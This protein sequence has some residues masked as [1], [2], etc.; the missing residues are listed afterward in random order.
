[1]VF[2]H[3]AWRGPEGVAAWAA[4]HT[5]VCGCACVKVD[6][7]VVDETVLR[8]PTSAEVTG[9]L[10]NTFRKNHDCTNKTPHTWIRNT[11]ENLKNAQHWMKDSARC[12]HATRPAAQL[13]SK[14]LFVLAL[15]ASWFRWACFGSYHMHDR[16]CPSHVCSPMRFQAAEGDQV[17]HPE[18]P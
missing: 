5:C 15:A 7:L 13:Y 12:V 11:E 4:F 18:Q 8:I 16:M 14:R 10:S 6:A 9:T 1:M 17:R 3:S 2:V